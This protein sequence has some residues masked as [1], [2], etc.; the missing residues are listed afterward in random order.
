MK[1]RIAQYDP[2]FS[3]AANDMIDKANGYLLIATFYDN[4]GILAHTSTE[5]KDEKDTTAAVM[6]LFSNLDTF[7]ENM[8]VRFGLPMERMMNSHVVTSIMP[9][10]SPMPPSHP[11]AP[12]PADLTN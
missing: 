5:C 11:P 3:K 8:A 7:R 2:A 9:V 12:P 1:N 10:G 4:Q 6:E